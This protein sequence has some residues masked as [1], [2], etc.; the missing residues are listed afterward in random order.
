MKISNF[1]NLKESDKCILH[2]TV[3]VETGCLWWKKI[4]VEDISRPRGES[5]IFNSTGGYTPGLVV[6]RLEKAYNAKISLEALDA[7][8]L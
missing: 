2:A 8:R 4:S 6:E 1:R 5:W 7:K 3:D